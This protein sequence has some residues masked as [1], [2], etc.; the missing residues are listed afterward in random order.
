[1]KHT[2]LQSVIS[3]KVVTLNCEASLG[4]ALEMMAEKSVSSLVMVDDAVRPIG[5]FTEH[6]ALKCI[7]INYPKDT[8]LSSVMSN[9]VVTVGLDEDVHDAY[10]LM[11]A[12]GFRHI[13]VVDE[14]G[15]LV[16]LASQ[17]DFLRHIGLEQF[18]S[19]K[20]TREVMNKSLL[21]IDHTLTLEESAGRMNERGVDYAIVMDNDVSKGL[22]TER[23][24]TLC[25]AKGGDAKSSVTTCWHTNYPTI[26]ENTPLQDAAMMM[27]AHGV[28][29]LIVVSEKDKL[30]GLLGRDEVLQAIHGNY[31][32]YLISLVDEKSAAILKMEASK[33]QLAAD[34]ELIEKSEA[35]FKALFELL[36]YGVFMVDVVSG[37]PLDFNAVAHDQ[38]GYTAQEFA[39]MRITDYE[40]VENEEEH[41]AHLKKIRD[42]GHDLFETKFRCKD[43]SLIDV[44]VNVIYIALLD[45]PY[46]MAVCQDITQKKEALRLEREQQK[47]FEEQASF[48]RTLVDTIPDLIW[49]K[50]IEGNYLACNPM[51]E[52]FFGAKEADILG[53]TDFDFVDAQ[54]AQFF[55]DHDNLA[56]E[57]GGARNNEEFLTFA[58]GSYE[59][60]FDTVKTPMKDELGSAIGVLGIARDVSERKRKDDETKKVQELSHIG[61]WEWDILRNE[62]S[63]S[64]EAYRIFSIPLGQKIS[65]EELHSHVFADDREIFESEM[66]KI[67]LGEV[68]EI[69]YRI[70]DGFGNVKW[71]ESTA[72]T[73][74]NKDNQPY[75]ATGLTRDVTVRKLHEQKLETLA[76]YDVLTGLANRPF[77]LAHL[78][79]ALEK[80]SRD[81]RIIALLMFDLDRF[82]DV[83]DSFGHKAGNALLVWVATRFSERMREGDLIARLG[84]DEF[85]IVLDNLTH[86]EDAGRIAEE[87]LI[88]LRTEYDLGDGVK[89]HTG[90]SAGI[91]ISPNHGKVAEEL[92]QYADAALYRAKDE[93]RGIFR[94]YTDELTEAARKRVEC[95]TQLRRAIENE[96]FEV[97]YQPQVHMA[98]GRIVGAEALVRWN[99]PERG[100]ISPVLF[101]PLAEETGL[102]GAIGEWVLNETCRQG[103]IWMD[104]GYRL[105]LAVNVSAHQMR[106]QDIPDMVDRA[107]KKSGYKAEHLELE[108]TESALMDREEELV[109]VLH[110]LRA[111]GIR[112]A[113]DDFGTGYSSLSYLKRFPIDILKID[114]S[115]VDDIPF[116]EDDMAIV[117]AI[118]AMGKALGFQILAEG[119]ER[120]EQIDFLMERGCTMYQGYFKSK[121]VPAAEFEKLLS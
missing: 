47:A 68:P 70:V 87:M 97:Y 99:D 76:N 78:K 103:K 16:G 36:P 20:M 55:R 93:G 88:A 28:H 2:K 25:I 119:T 75:K 105:T 50:D 5:I 38:I 81:N 10:A 40:A 89:V 62:F 104:A 35:K 82:K 46:L 61:T 58:D 8:L 54:L 112:L 90:A 13:V 9:G 72:T 113:I 96:E 1:M 42:D 79:N 64:D 4:H 109:E 32:E 18:V 26:H 111:R 108:L 121:P 74:F 22:I 19:C 117:T 14:K 3:G 67:L 100:I 48:L 49:L 83:N 91:V 77:L 57:S 107:L 120:Q 21:M 15:I 95:E 85:A 17:G 69:S 73:F 71:L 63:G 110:I 41:Q 116:E 53:K 44:E 59:G 56:I 12:R 24:L 118:I 101:I 39:Q 115:F 52:R 7:A 33:Q 31:F 43:G 45:H 84:G 6:D 66:A 102:I 94:Y 30:V 23:D 65:L 92:L 51:F 29:Q 37:L 114:K 34:K 106:H 27:E 11:S 60:L 98:T 80:A 86:I